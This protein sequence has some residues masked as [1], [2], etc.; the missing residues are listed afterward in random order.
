MIVSMTRP[1]KQP[2]GGNESSEQASTSLPDYRRVLWFAFWINAVMFVVELFGAMS[3]QALSLLA[4][5]IDFFGDAGNYLVSLLV[6]TASPARRAGVALFKGTVMAGFGL[7]ICVQIYS[8]LKAGTVPAALTM[9]VI[10]L[11]ALLANLAVTAVLFPHREGDANRRSV[12]LATR[13]DALSNLAVLFA[14][15][16]VF[17]T[18]SGWPDLTV[19][20]LMAALALTSAWSVIRQAVAELIHPSQ[21]GG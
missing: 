9:G 13:N 3:A 6:L 5:A 1:L 10:G 2:A 7:F 15:A 16:G 14:A 19:A 17:G 4:D 20:A 8:H 21:Q 18:Q 11:L 12:W